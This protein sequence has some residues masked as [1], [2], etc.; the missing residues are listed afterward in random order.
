MCLGLPDAIYIRDRTAS[1]LRA[2][3]TCMSRRAFNEANHRSKPLANTSQA[4]I[5]HRAEREPPVRSCLDHLHRFPR[6][7]LPSLTAMH[8]LDDFVSQWAARHLTTSSNPCFA[9]ACSLIC[10]RPSPVSRTP[11]LACC[12]V[13]VLSNMKRESWRTMR[14]RG[15][16][17]KLDADA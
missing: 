1:H 15:Q 4:C 6:S 9:S 11:P 5:D 17:P 7:R 8:S 3:H 2:S 14:F 13:L 12:A 10:T 16:H